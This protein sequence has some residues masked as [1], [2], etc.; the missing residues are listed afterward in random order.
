MVCATYLNVKILSEEGSRGVNAFN[1][2][3]KVTIGYLWI[4]FYA[5]LAILGKSERKHPADKCLGVTSLWQE[6]HQQA[7][8][9]L[10]F[11][12]HDRVWENSL[13]DLSKR[14]VLTLQ[15]LRRVT[16]ELSS[17]CWPEVIP[18]LCFAPDSWKI[19]LQL[20]PRHAA[21]INNLHKVPFHHPTWLL[22]Y[23]S[24]F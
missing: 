17:H 24:Q 9:C 5:N 1:W 18:T 22:N 11:L 14:W 20:L 23:M 6:L 21:E 8:S 12:S 10:S 19:T 4:G 2:R 7:G 15:M 16:M 13:E 3:E